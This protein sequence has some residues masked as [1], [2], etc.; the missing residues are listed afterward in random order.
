MGNRDSTPTTST[1]LETTNLCDTSPQA[2]VRGVAT[3]SFSNLHVGDPVS[4]AEIAIDAWVANGCHDDPWNCTGTQHCLRATEYSRQRSPEQLLDEIQAERSTSSGTFDLILEG[5]WQD[6]IQGSGTGYL[7]TLRLRCLDSADRLERRT[8][9][10]TIEWHLVSSANEDNGY[11]AWLRSQIGRSG[12]ERVKGMLHCYM[13]HDEP[14]ASLDLAGYCVVD[15]MRSGFGNTMGILG[16]DQYSMMWLQHRGTFMGRTRCYRESSDPEHWN[17]SIFQ[18]KLMESNL[19]ELVPTQ[20]LAREPSD[21]AVCSICLEG[22]VHRVVTPCGH[23]FCAACICQAV[24]AV[25]AGGTGRCPMC[26]DLVAVI[27]LC[28]GST[29]LPLVTKEGLSGALAPPKE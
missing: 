1:V 15:P 21:T 2:L 29:G 19:P 8:V 13:D 3:S 9:S 27:S 26:R 7:L 16:P 14:K 25:D 22:F 11:L 28:Y 17:T 20:S 6:S 4:E 5:S 10:G 24:L 23:S 18:A 12:L